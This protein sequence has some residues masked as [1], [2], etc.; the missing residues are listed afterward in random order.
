MSHDRRVRREDVHAQGPRA[1][2]RRDARDA[3][4][5]AVPQ[6]GRGRV[7]RR[8]RHRGEV[9]GGHASARR[10]TPTRTA[11]RWA[12]SAPSCHSPEDWRNPSTAFHKS[13]VFPLE[14]RHLAVPCASCHV[15]G[16][17]KGTPTRCYDCHWVRRQDDLYKTR[18]GNECEDC[19]RPTSWTAVNWDH[20]SRTG[21][22]A[23]HRAPAARVRLVPQEPGRSRARGPS[24]SRATSATTRS[25]QNAQPQGRRLPD[26]LHGLPQRRRRRRSPGARFDHSTFQR[27]GRARD[28]R[29][30]TAAT[31]TA[32]TRARRATASAATRPT[33]SARPNPNHAAAGV[34]DDVRVVPPQH[35]SELAGR[36]RSTTPPVLPAGRAR[37][38]R[39][40][41]RAATR[42]ASTRARRATAS[43][44][45]R[46]T[47]SAAAKPEPRGRGLPDDV[48]DV[49]PA[50]AS[51]WQ[52][53]T[54]SHT[55]A[56]PAAR[57]ALA[58]RRAR[59]ATRTT[60]T[61]ARRGTAC[62]CHQP[63][64]QRAASPN[65]V[66]AG[67]P[68][69][70]V[71]C[72]R[73]GGPGWQNQALHPHQR[74]PADGDRT[75][76]ARVR[77]VPQ[78]RHLQGHVVAT[79]S[80]CH[81]ADYQRAADA[82][83]RDGGL[84][85]G[86]RDV[87]PQRRPGL[88]R[89]HVHPH[90]RVSADRARTRRRP[91]RRATRT[92]STRARRATASAATSPTT[93]ARPIPNHVTAGFPT[94][95]ESVPQERRSRAG[96]SGSFTHNQYLDA[97]G[98]S[99][100]GR[101]RD[102]PQEQR[103]QGHAARLRRLPPA[104]LQ[105]DDRTRT[106][107]R[108]ASRRRASRATATA[109]PAGRA[110]RSTTAPVLPA[111]RAC[112]PR[113]SARACHKNNV[114]KGTSRDCVRLPPGR[115]PARR[116]TRTTPAAGFPTACESC[117]KNGG[118]GWTGAH[119][120]P[121]PVRTRC[122]GSHATA[123]CASCHK[124]NVYKGT[125]RDCVGCHQPNY[126]RGDQ[127]RTT[128]RRRSRRPAS[129][130]TATAGP[131]GPA[132]RS[133]TT[134]SGR[135]RAATAAPRARAATR[136]TST[137]AR[138]A[139]ACSCHQADYQR[140][141]NPNHASAGLPDHVRVV[142]QERRARLDRAPR[143]TTARRWPLQGSHAT[144]ACASCHKNNVYKGTPRD[145]V[146]CHQPD[147]QRAA[148]PE[149]R[150][151]P[152]SRRRASRATATAARA[153]RTR[154]SRTTSTGRCTGTHASTACARATRTTS[155]RARRATASAATRPT[156]TRPR[157]RTTSR[158][159]SRPRASRAT[160]NGGP[161]WTSH[162]QPQHVRSRCVGM[163][164]TTA[165][166]ERAT[167][168]T[169]TR[170][171]RATASAATRP[172]TRRRRT[173]ITRR[174]ASRRR[175]RSCHKNGGPGWTGATFN[176]NVD[177]SRCWAVTRRRPARRCHKNNVYK[178]TPR[179]C[180]GC[181]QT[182]YNAHDEPEPRRR[183]ASRPRASR[184]TATA[185][186]GWSVDVQPQ[187][188]VPA[189]GHARHQRV[190][191]RAT[192]TTSTRAR[193]ATASAA[194]RRST[195]ATTNPNH[196]AA[197]FPTTCESCHKT[198]DPAGRGATFNHNTVLRAR[199]QPRDAAVRDAATRTT[200]TRARR[201][202]ASGC[203]QTNYNAT[204]NPNHAAAGFPTDV[205]V[206]PR[207]GGPGLER[208]RFNHSATFTLLGMHATTQCSSVPQE[209]RL[210]G[211]AARLLRLPPGEVTR[212]RRARTTWRR[213]SRRRARRATRTAAP[214]WTPA[215]FNHSTF[216]ALAGHARHA[217]VHRV[218]QEQRLQGH[219]ARLRRLPP[220]EVQRDDEPEPPRGGLP[221][222]VRDL[223][224][225][226]GHRVDAGHVQPHVVPDHDAA[227]T[228]ATRA[229]RATTTRTTT[230]CSAA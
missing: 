51:S 9:Q 59:R 109:A 215:T 121:Q 54:F 97:A 57:L 150:R 128:S 22:A 190:Q 144:T 214:G 13:T 224:P 225:R 183:P 93:S 178:G 25:T 52:G 205:R 21:H 151:R 40:P 137:R 108:R 5:R 145:C 66:A 50:T 167:R 195:S 193:R 60:S 79:A 126:Q 165:L 114:Y 120:Q 33:T 19:H 157:T 141:A 160:R 197:G 123:A 124:N 3:R 95:C 78:E 132:R 226:D 179:D 71:T 129:R 171:P 49:S 130:V 218:P 188:D 158:P 163:H 180:V 86:V 75:R 36:R 53:A 67:F 88:D 61:R 56:V 94:T 146:G 170:A 154:P 112:T 164:A 11:A 147:F 76:T 177:R 70:C 117:H 89:G 43:A 159:A 194:T 135:C 45:T 203:H 73:E 222:D 227:G 42:T 136:T 223:P 176:H 181:H 14:G 209:Q 31:G 99:H 74:V 228:P 12:R 156:T 28:A 182:N 211:H 213:A 118:P 106:T 29:R 44:A 216:F 34:P 23:Q 166:R 119:V 185:D 153:G 83:P 65:H 198:A 96:R 39:R 64:Y 127:S 139:T 47:T 168:T 200:S 92:A 220:R 38:R 84:P 24:A 212:R 155:T 4:V 80:R 169:S 113:R 100:D 1:L 206:V 105:R 68:T 72:H 17:L 10:A 85:D 98:Q 210:Q 201:A 55:S 69:T 15:K 221:D 87:P 174:R 8:P 101:V 115:L 32:S 172:S 230:R 82:E 111:A 191:R 62:R 184:A 20:G 7:P 91:A 175:A 133:T 229:R 204:T 143:S 125:P 16:Q 148:N 81:Q 162:L 219:A 18:L 35:R 41:A 2:L 30:A 149:P 122:T 116:P 199:G 192:R 58:R 102:L 48:R 26:R 196:A 63:D 208:R 202:T 207:N 186:P 161:G 27:V 134:S 152:T 131:A 104:E 77:V 138:R 187:H 46:P 37:T 110:R 107:S 173:R 90:Q 103:L 140:A 6:E 217:A 142:P 189:G